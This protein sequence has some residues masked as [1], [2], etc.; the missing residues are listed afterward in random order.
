[1]TPG[2]SDRADGRVRELRGLT[3]QRLQSHAE[4]VALLEGVVDDA[5]TA[6]KPAFA[7][8]QYRNDD[9]KPDPPKTAIAVSVVTGS[10]SRR[11]LKED[12]NLTVQ[13]EH[14][15]RA[16]VRPSIGGEPLGL[17]PWHDRIADEISA[18][19]TTQ[20][21]GWQAEGETGGTPEPLWDGDRNRYRSV[22]RFDISGYGR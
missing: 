14:E 11:N 9:S 15:F 1:M 2:T 18:V 20:V 13:I 19:M 5:S 16:N 8:T 17:L 22:K 12:V 10:S 3:L 7:M 21:E 4:L 6:I